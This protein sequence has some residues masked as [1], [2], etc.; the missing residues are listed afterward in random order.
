VCSDETVGNLE[1]D[2]FV[3]EVYELGLPTHTDPK[4]IAALDCVILAGSLTTFRLIRTTNTRTP[5]G[6]AG[7][8]G[9]GPAEF[10]VLVGD[11][12]IKLVLSL[13]RS[14]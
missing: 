10:V 12:S 8:I 2:E 7:A 1:R 5:I 9:S 11:H 6:M 14:A 4:E 13:G 3:G